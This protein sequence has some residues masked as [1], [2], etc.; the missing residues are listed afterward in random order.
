MQQAISALIFKKYRYGDITWLA[1]E[2]GVQ[3]HRH[4]A[5]KD[6]KLSRGTELSPH[7]DSALLFAS[8]QQFLPDKIAEMPSVSAGSSRLVAV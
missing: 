8:D 7:N 3:E 6:P 5:T 2:P 4:S 1:R